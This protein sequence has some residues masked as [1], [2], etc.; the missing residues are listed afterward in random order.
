ML[1]EK[2]F[3]PSLERAL[4]IL[5]PLSETL[6]SIKGEKSCLSSVY[7]AWNKIKHNVYNITVN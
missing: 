6:L 5:K 1:D 4:T 2:S 3:W 7:V